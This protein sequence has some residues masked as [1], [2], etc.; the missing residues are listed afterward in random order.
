M[1]PPAPPTLGVLLDL[2]GTSYRGD[3]PIQAYAR[4]VAEQLSPAVGI[5][6]IDGMRH[7][8]E[9]R[10]AFGSPLTDVSAAEDG[11]EAVHLLADAAGLNVHARRAAYFQSRDDLARSAFILD[12]EPGLARFLTELKPRSRVWIVT[13]API[14]GIREV[15]QAV[16]L[17][18]LVDE[19]IPGAG[20]PDRLPEVVEGALAAIGA[21]S[22]PERLLGIGDRWAA[23]LAAIHHAGGV[24]AHV[25]RF[26]LRRGSPRWRAATLTEMIPSLQ[27]WAADLAGV[28]R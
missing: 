4:R 18:T 17:L 27:V 15:L 22:H 6:V 13:N 12:P 14:T 11:Y 9:G 7:F 19:I 21:A 8:L 25:D 5:Q 2:D 23:D 24:T 10:P 1:T 16:G 20:K 3:L 28:A 26:D